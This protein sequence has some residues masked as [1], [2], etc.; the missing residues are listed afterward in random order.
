VKKKGRDRVFE[1]QER[2]RRNGEEEKMEEEK[3]D[4]PHLALIAIGSYE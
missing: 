4:P 1:R 2:E 3:D